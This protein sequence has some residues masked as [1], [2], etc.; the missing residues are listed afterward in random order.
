M[1]PSTGVCGSGVQAA[2]PIES[3]GRR[4][5]PQQA[6][7]AALRACVQVTVFPGGR[8]TVEGKSIRLRSHSASARRLISPHPHPLIAVVIN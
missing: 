5:P 2:H 7:A 1:L 3:I 8:I 6:W 4:G